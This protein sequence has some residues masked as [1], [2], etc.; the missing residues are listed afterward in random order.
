MQNVS[1]PGSGS[2]A[3]RSRFPTLHPV[4]ELPA[5]FRQCTAQL[6]EQYR[7]LYQLPVTEGPGGSR[8]F[9]N[10]RL[11][12]R[13]GLNVLFLRGDFFEMA[14]QHGRLLADQIPTGA[15]PESSRLVSDSI[16][17]ALGPVDRL[18]KRIVEYIQWFVVQRLFSGSSRRIAESGVGSDQSL[19]EAIAFADA[20]GLPAKDFIQSLFNP[21][22]LLL[23]SKYG[24]GAWRSNVGRKV[25]VPPICCSSFAAWGSNTKCGEMLIGH[26]MDFPLNGSYDRFPTVIYFEPPAPGLRYMTFVSAGVPNAGI[27]AYNEAGI[28]LAAHVVPTTDT[29][30]GGVPALITANLAIRQ[31]KSFD[32]V[33]DIFQKLKPLAGWTFLV[34][35]LSERKI[36]TIEVSH[37]RVQVRPATVGHLVQ[38]N[39]FRTEAMSGLNLFINKSVDD[40]AEARSL[41]LEQRIKEAVGRVDVEAAISMLGD[42]F[43][44]FSN[45]VRGLG[46]TIAVHLTMTS[47][48][49]DAA[50]QEVLVSTGAA[51]ASHS[52]FV[53]LPLAGQVESSEFPKWISHKISPRHPG[54]HLAISAALQTFIRAKM[55]YEQKNDADS[56]YRLLQLVV[57]QD[58]SN[59]AYFFQLG[60]FALKNDAFDAARDAFEKA[61]HCP[62]LPD[63]LR[64]LTHYYRG[65]LLAHQ[66]KARE[67]LGEFSVVLNDEGTDRKL[68]KAARRVAWR[69]K[70]FGRSSLSKRNLN[71]MM[72]QSDMVDY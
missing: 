54:A 29:G 31:A 52:D 22:L 35:S 6:R 72:Q 64:R 45:Q 30:I 38:T 20:T 1:S 40:D 14:F 13:H 34:A 65:R 46:N 49:L 25:C 53:A 67:A 47:I 56:A 66:A 37:S 58:S 26:N 10:A 17:N 15:V 18:P 3:Q 55:A 51:P 23:L 2:D 8:L 63:Q 33:V 5:L 48:V 12:R 21:D 59:P 36:G 44:P 57:E 42:Q 32:S 60:I 27:I 7:S 43:D 4:R 11:Y 9:H 69:T 68:R 24:G 39:Y 16:I 70:V 61:F 28:F 41:R 50:K 19:L 71:I 62:Y